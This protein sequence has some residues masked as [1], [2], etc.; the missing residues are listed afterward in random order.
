MNYTREQL[1]AVYNYKVIKARNCF[2]TYRR[3]I[4]PS[5]KFNWFVED[6]T[7]NLEQ[8]V[9]DYEDGK[10]PMMIIAARHRHHCHRRS[11]GKVKR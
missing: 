10:R 3:L 7:R 6:I 4:N 11:M 9:F 5:I 1:H 8:F 2:L